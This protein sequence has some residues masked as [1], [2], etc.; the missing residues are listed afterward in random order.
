MQT[1]PVINTLSIDSHGDRV[2]PTETDGKVTRIQRHS[3]Y[4]KRIE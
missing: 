2:L 1:I 4:L 3:S